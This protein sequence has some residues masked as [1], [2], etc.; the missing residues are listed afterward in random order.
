MLLPLLTT[1]AF[2]FDDTHAAFQKVLD[3]Y[4][5]NGRVDYAHLHADH[6]ALDAY[7]AELT[8]ASLDGLTAAQK[9]ALYINAYNAWTLRY[10][11]EA[12]PV[13]SPKDVDGG[14]MWDTR[15][16]NVGGKPMS[17]NDIENKVLRPMGDPRIHAAL[18]CVGLNCDA[19]C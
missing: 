9:E 12:S 4:V 18:N 8:N 13:A 1:L 19:I 17:L 2:A 10:L 15:H 3:A 11:A 5:A 6:A 16:F 14:K 7:L